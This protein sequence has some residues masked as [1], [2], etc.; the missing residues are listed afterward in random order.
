MLDTLST[1]SMRENCR[2]NVQM[3]SC[4]RLHKSQATAVL[5]CLFVTVVISGHSLCF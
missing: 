1:G 3:Q 4:L 5:Q 2:H